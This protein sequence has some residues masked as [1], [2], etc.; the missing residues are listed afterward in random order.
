MKDDVI[1]R[2]AAIDDSEVKCLYCGHH[3]TERPFEV[4]C[5][6]M[7]KWFNEKDYCGMFEP[8]TQSERKSDA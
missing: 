4:Y 3:I 7:C 1:S 8:R 5:N 6:I 2:Q